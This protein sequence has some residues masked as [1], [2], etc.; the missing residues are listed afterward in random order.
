MGPNEP[1]ST[2]LAPEEEALIAAFR[3]YTLLPL[4]GCLYALQASVPPDGS[5]RWSSHASVTLLGFGR[6]EGPN[7]LIGVA[8][9]MLRLLG[10]GLG[11]YGVG[12][13]AW[14]M[15]DLTINLED[16]MQPYDAFVDGVQ[17]GLGWPVSL[18]AALW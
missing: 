2:S 1:R 15:I 6:I 3:K 16:G 5:I 7:E 14:F 8:A 13:F 10:W 4:D 12:A 18:I 9:G 17:T 11:L